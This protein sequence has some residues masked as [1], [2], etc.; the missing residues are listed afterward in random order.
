M[1]IHFSFHQQQTQAAS[2]NIDGLL[3]R[4]SG[5]L[6]LRTSQTQRLKTLDCHDLSTFMMIFSGKSY[7]SKQNC[8]STLVKTCAKYLPD[9]E[10]MW[11]WHISIKSLVSAFQIYSSDIF[12]HLNKEL[13][14]SI[15]LVSCI[16][17]VH[18]I[19]VV[20]CIWPIPAPN[21][22]NKKLFQPQIT[23]TRDGM[24]IGKLEGTKT[25]LETKMLEIH[26]ITAW[27][28]LWQACFLGAW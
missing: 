22:K 26:I 5:Y 21:K 12:R 8:C 20:S 23:T 28:Q 15:S 7:E 1:I 25:N 17:N 2:P 6:H 13:S 19:H 9:C 24:A 3:D 4:S 18:S 10:N 14:Y 16:S 11:R 27:G